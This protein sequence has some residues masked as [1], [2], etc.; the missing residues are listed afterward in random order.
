[1]NTHYKRL[2]Y[3][4]RVTDITTKL[5]HEVR[6]NLRIFKTKTIESVVD[7]TGRYLNC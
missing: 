2:G 5:K 4:S 3:R 6:R 1:M 7:K